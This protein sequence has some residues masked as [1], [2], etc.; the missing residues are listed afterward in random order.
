MRVLV[1]GLYWS[2]FRGRR[3]SESAAFGLVRAERRFWTGASRRSVEV[4]IERQQ[5]V[6]PRAPS[7]SN[8]QGTS[9]R[10]LQARLVEGSEGDE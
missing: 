9:R 5:E 2:S 4:A 1:W 10:L 6:A 3:M 7:V 8:R